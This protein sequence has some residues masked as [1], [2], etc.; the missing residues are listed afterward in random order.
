M[1]RKSR[2]SPARRAQA[3][4]RHRP[5]GTIAPSPSPAEATPEAQPAAPEQASAPPRP[6]RPRVIARPAPS[7][8]RAGQ[9]APH[10]PLLARELQRIG[11]VSGLAL[12]VLVVLYFVLK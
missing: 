3:V 6:A 11:L 12:V 4:R 10:N 8:P 5:V 1:P 2:R 7:A 9:P